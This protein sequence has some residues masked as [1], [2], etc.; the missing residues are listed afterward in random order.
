MRNSFSF[1][2]QSMNKFK[3]RK[4]AKYSYMYVHVLMHMYVSMCIVSTFYLRKHWIYVITFD[5]N[6]VIGALLYA[7]LHFYAFAQADAHTRPFTWR[8]CI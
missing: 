1:N 3:R 4:C 6:R 5:V 7:S 8:Y 2:P